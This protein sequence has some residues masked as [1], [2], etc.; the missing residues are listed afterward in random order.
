MICQVMPKANAQSQ[1]RNKN[2]LTYYTIL[3]LTTKCPILKWFS[4]ATDEVYWVCMKYKV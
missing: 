2:I 1:I 4:F 3:S